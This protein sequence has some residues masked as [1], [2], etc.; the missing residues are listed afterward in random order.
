M[1]KLYC[2]FVKIL[3]AFIPVQK[4]RKKFRSAAFHKPFGLLEDSFREI[5]A[6]R[7]AF[8]QAADTIE[9]LFLGSS[10]VA[11]GFNPA[12]YSPTSFNFGT[13]SQDLFTS[14]QLFIKLEKS[15]PQLKKVFL[16]YDIFSRGWALDHS[17]AAHICSCFNYLYGIDYRIPNYQKNFKKHCAKQRTAVVSTETAKGYLHPAKRQITDDVYQRRNGHLREHNRSVTQLEWIEK[18]AQ[19]I[20]GQKENIASKQAK[21]CLVVFPLRQDFREILPEPDLLFQEAQD[22]SARLGIGFISLYNDTDFTTEDFY[23]FDHLNPTGAK[24]F[25]EKLKELTL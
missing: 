15:L 9:T 13:N 10:H 16:S 21:L 6:K 23:D 14:Y 1:H 11:Y 2:V 20:N 3:S 24:K 19:I 12:F 4:W 22:L 7:Q 25:S 18:L 8:N 17:S 5:N